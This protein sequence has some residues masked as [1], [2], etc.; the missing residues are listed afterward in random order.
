MTKKEFDSI[1]IGDIVTISIHGKNK[2]KHGIV[3]AVFKD[4]EFRKGYVYLRPLF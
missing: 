3:E 1:H 4:N 2:G